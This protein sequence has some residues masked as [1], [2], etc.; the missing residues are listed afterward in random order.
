M[1]LRIIEGQRRGDVV[2]TMPGASLLSATSSG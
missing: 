1:H 2:S